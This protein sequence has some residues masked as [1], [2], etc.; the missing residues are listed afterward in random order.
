MIGEPVQKWNDQPK[1]TGNAG[2]GGGIGEYPVLSPLYRQTEL[3][4]EVA[5]ILRRHDAGDFRASAGMV[6]EIKTDDRLLGLIGT[7]SAGLLSC[8]VQITA[9]RPKRKER[10]VALDIGGDGQDAK[11]I[12]RDIINPKAIRTLQVWGWFLGVGVAE[13]VVDQSTGLVRLLPWHP[14]QLRWD[15]SYDRFVL[16]TP[17]GMVYLPR[18]DVEKPDGK[19]F[20][21]CPF[22]VK[23]GWRDAFIRAVAEKYLILRWCERD[24]ARFCEKHG[25][26]I[27]EARVP[28]NASNQGERAQFLQ[29]LENLG[30]EGIVLSPQGDTGKASYGIDL[31]EAVSNTWQAFM[32]FK[33]SLHT[34]FAVLLLGQNLTTESKGGGLGGGE[35]QTHDRVRGE[36]KEF[37]A[38]IGPDIQTQILGPYV[39]NVYGDRGLTPIFSFETAES[40]DAKAIGEGHLVTA[41][42]IA[43]YQAAGVEVNGDEMA[44]AAGAPM[45]T[46][47]DIAA[48]QADRDQEAADAAEEAATIAA[49]A[50]AAGDNGTD[51]AALAD[52]AA[53]DPAKASLRAPTTP[54]IRERYTF[55]G[56]PI[57]VENKAGSLRHWTDVNGTVTGTTQMQNDY[58]FIEGYLGEDGEELDCYVGPDE[59]APDVHV[60]HQLMAPDF[61]AHDEMKV[62]L[63]ARDS[64]HAKEIYLAHRNEP[65]AFGAMTTFPLDRFRAKLSRRKPE[66]TTRIRATAPRAGVAKLKAPA[67]VPRKV[68]MYIDQLDAAAQKRGAA[69]IR[70]SLE[71]ILAAVRDGTSW[72]DIRSRALAH[73][74]TGDGKAIAETVQRARIMAHLSGRAAVLD[75]I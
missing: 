22:G 10:K 75:T 62:I 68:T 54:Q 59:N 46:P 34:D 66:T 21:Y 24:W 39:E 2:V 36:I 48:R 52:G 51:A 43:A 31:K 9:A 40:A 38:E 30:S 25:L 29:G 19:W 41:Q 69:S 26:A 47:E 74:K 15:H 17:R 35:A 73:L 57:A 32:E 45:R 61:K 64:A 28:A 23:L 8:P 55:Q 18:P 58:G 27:V 56:F 70:P 20:L 44:I 12:W 16:N 53:A 37:D 49:A 60:V 11:G 33:R 4:S 5:D 1:F 3:K 7:R 67:G 71:A 42:A 65:Q 6:D 50:K 13:Q 14:S 63:G 72:A